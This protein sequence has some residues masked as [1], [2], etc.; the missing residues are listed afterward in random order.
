MESWV[1]LRGTRT[2]DR[3]EI[4]GGKL[5]NDVSDGSI[6]GAGFL[7]RGIE[8]QKFIGSEK[9]FGLDDG[10][11]GLVDS[12]EAAIPVALFV[13]EGLR[14]RLET[15]HAG[16]FLDAVNEES[17]ARAAQDEHQRSV[18]GREAEVDS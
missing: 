5:G 12:G 16:H 18:R 1:S 13:M 2:Y 4:V 9:A 14:E 8:K 15:S 3:V 7:Q 17:G 11:D 6:G 10:N